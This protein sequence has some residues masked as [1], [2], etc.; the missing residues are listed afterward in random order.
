MWAVSGRGGLVAG[1]VGAAAEGVAA[2]RDAAAGVQDDLFAIAIPAGRRLDAGE[3]EGEA[4]RTRGPGRPKGAENRS[5]RELR[6]WIMRET[7]LPQ[8]QMARWGSMEPE[9][10]AARL[11]CS[12]VEAFRELRALWAE[13]GGYLMPKMAPTDGAGNAVPTVLFAVGGAGGMELQAGSV[14]PWEAARLAL[15]AAAGGDGDAAGEIVEN[16]G[17]GEG[18]A[19]GAGE[20]RSQA[21]EKA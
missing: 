5:T 7:I 16:Q 19:G 13:L 4:E 1:L 14:P 21:G 10:L 15:E 18:A 8:Q 20:D 11:G 6:A 2:E 17:L 9:E 3:V 12:K